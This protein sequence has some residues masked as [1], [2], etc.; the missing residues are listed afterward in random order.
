M[1][2]NGKGVAKDYFKA[3][4]LYKNVAELGNASAQLNLVICMK[5]AWE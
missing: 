3:F 2:E 4:D 1:Y 5:G